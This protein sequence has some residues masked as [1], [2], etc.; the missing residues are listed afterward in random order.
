MSFLY[1]VLFLFTFVCF[2]AADG[3][4]S[5]VPLPLPALPKSSVVRSFANR[6][7]S[8][9]HSLSLIRLCR[10]GKRKQEMTVGKS[11]AEQA[12]KVSTS[13]ALVHLQYFGRE[14]ESEV[15]TGQG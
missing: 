11:C 10:V 2:D 13:H 1:L 5:T 8:R 9:K 15:L 3:R 7:M 6:E 4:S 14:R 12:A